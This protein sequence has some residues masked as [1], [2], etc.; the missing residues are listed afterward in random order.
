MRSADEILMSESVI[1][2][3]AKMPRKFSRW[4]WNS[5]RA[6]GAGHLMMTT[7]EFRRKAFTSSTFRLRDAKLKRL[8]TAELVVQ[9]A[10]WLETKKGHAAGCWAGSSSEN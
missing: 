1:W 5:G 10:A 9:L 7:F 6:A 4:H 3:T 8:A 2:P